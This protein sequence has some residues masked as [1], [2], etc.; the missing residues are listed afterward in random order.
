[1]EGDWDKLEGAGDNKN[2][3][4]FLPRGASA[5]EKSKA[6]T[7]INL[8]GSARM[9]YAS[10]LGPAPKLLSAWLLSDEALD[11]TMERRY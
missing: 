9:Y 8:A 6:E 10:L 3:T 1:V 7:L 4:A 2:I 11:S 5:D